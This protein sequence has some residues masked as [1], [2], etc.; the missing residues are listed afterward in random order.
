MNSYYKLIYEFSAVNLYEEYLDLM[1]EFLQMNSH[2]KS[3]TN[4]LILN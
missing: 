3:W 2:M 4:S 1:Q